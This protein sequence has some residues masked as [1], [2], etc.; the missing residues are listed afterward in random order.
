VSFMYEE[1]KRGKFC[2]L[3][4]IR[5]DDEG[6]TWRDDDKTRGLHTQCAHHRGT[7]QLCVRCRCHLFLSAF[8]FTSALSSLSPFP[9]S[10][11]FKYDN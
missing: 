9:S 11:S 6:M 1:R 4:S 7:R 3:S 2:P 5:D 10:P 8:P